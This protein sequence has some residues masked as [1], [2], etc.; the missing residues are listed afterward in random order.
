MKDDAYVD[1]QVMKL[2]TWTK[3]D[4]DK[5]FGIPLVW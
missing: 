4:I 2:P 1:R 5:E 3:F